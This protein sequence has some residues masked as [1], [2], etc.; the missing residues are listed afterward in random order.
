MLVATLNTHHGAEAQR[1]RA[2]PDKFA[3]A[4]EALQDVDILA[5]QEVDKGVIRSGRA[6]LAAIAAKS[7]GMEL[8][9]KP[10]MT[11]KTGQ[12]G[13]A[14][15]VRG[16]IKDEQVVGLG[17]GRR[18]NKK[19]GPFKLSVGFEP[20]NAIV[21]TAVVGGH[22]ISV[23]ATHLSTQAHL[24]EKQLEKVI[25]KLSRRRGPKILLGDLNMTPERASPH[26]DAGS[27]ETTPETFTYPSDEEIKQLDYV[28]VQGLT[29]YSVEARR[30]P[31]S[32]H[33]ALVAEVA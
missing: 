16:E 8:C 9:F 2:N 21:A 20:R 6:D 14:L 10:T 29:I 24:K 22:E 31:V 15:L 4:C 12:Y 1:Y 27:L 30:L 28:A 17:G 33:L 26:F 11:Y 25:A 13:N 19:I 23:A 5:L 7:T 3:E 18:F 32:D